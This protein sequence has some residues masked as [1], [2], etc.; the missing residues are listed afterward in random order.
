MY[1]IIKHVCL[2]K[3]RLYFFALSMYNLNYSEKPMDF[4]LKPVCA[5]N[6]LV[7]EYENSIKSRSFVSSIHNDFSFLQS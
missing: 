4:L 3:P 6:F 2:L 5:I 7:E 1:F